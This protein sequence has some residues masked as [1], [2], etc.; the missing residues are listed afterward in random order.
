VSLLDPTTHSRS[1]TSCLGLKAAQQRERIFVR[2]IEPAIAVVGGGHGARRVPPLLTL[3]PVIRETN[4]WIG[5]PHLK[6]ELKGRWSAE[7]L[8]APSAPARKDVNQREEGDDDH[9]SDGNDGNGGS[10]E[11]HAA[12]LSCS[13]FVKT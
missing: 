10:G 11:D 1:T 9:R 12:F 4:F 7:W 6:I 5:G 2:L 3:Q 13:S 8:A